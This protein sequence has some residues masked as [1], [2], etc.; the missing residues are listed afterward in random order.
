M[1]I[2]FILFFS[3][4]FSPLLKK[5]K[6]SKTTQAPSWWSQVFKKKRN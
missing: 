4:L 1:A 6:Q 3:I 5:T 2:L